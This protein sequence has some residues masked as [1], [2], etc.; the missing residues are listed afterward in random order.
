MAE[1]DGVAAGTTVVTV[2]EA[3]AWISMVLVE[4]EFRGR[5]MGKAL[6]NSAVEVAEELGAKAIRLDATPLG[7]PLYEALGFAPQYEL[8]RYA[9]VA[10]SVGS[11]SS[12]PLVDRVITPKDLAAVVA[13]DSSATVTQRGKFLARLIAEESAAVRVC[14]HNGQ[15]SGYLMV[16][17]GSDALQLGPCIAETDEAGSAL[18]SDALRRY[19]GSRVFWDLPSSRSAAAQLRSPPASP[20]NG[21]FCGCAGGKP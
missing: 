7:K 19:A 20:P 2:F 15:I 21:S 14:E 6:M 3:V 4:R 17:L 13:L 1:L 16:R 18:L 9:G 8:T 12:S 11:A 10:A 5:G